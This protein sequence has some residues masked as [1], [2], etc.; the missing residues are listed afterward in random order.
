MVFNLNTKFVEITIMKT[1]SLMKT[2]KLLTLTFYL[3]AI[4]AIQAQGANENSMVTVNELGITVDKIQMLGTL[5]WTKTFSIFKDNNPGDSIQVFIKIKNLEFKRDD[6]SNITFNDLTL[7]VKGVSKNRD[8]LKKEINEK[9]I[10]LI[11]H[12]KE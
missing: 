3:F 7:S 9:I 12:F 10:T 8:E 1:M 6:L 2:I 4:S 5:N 11:K